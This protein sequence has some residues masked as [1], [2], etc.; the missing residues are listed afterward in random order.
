L[1]NVLT[2]QGH[3]D[4]ESDSLVISLGDDIIRRYHY[5]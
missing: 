4:I 2:H 5:R 1:N 3:T